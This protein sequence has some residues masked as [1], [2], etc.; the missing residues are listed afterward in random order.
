[1]FTIK[2]VELDMYVIL[3][4]VGSAIHLLH[5]LT[6]VEYSGGGSVVPYPGL[7]GGGA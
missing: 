2:V 7:K 6:T 1:M 4:E 3:L 5:C